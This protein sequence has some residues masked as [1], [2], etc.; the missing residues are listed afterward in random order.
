[1]GSFVGLVERN[2][3]GIL[4]GALGVPFL[5]ARML[6]GI[7]HASRDLI[8]IFHETSFIKL[9]S[10]HGLNLIWLQSKV[11]KKGRSTFEFFEVLVQKPDSLLGFC[12]DF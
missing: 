3:V 10:S 4:P 11:E 2:A 7:L 6:S 5:I 9:K 12:F 1:M 8:T